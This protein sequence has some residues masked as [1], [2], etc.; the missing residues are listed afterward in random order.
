MYFKKEQKKLIIKIIDNKDIIGILPTGFG[1]TLIYTFASLKKPFLTLVFSPLVALIKDQYNNLPKFIK[2]RT[3]FILN[4]NKKQWDLIFSKIN[5][6]K[7]KILYLSPE[8]LENKYILDKLNSFYISHIVLDEAHTFF[9][10]GQT[11]R[12]SFKK[13]AIFINQKRKKQNFSVSVFTATF[14]KKDIK[15]IKQKLFLKSPYILYKSPIRKNIKQ[16]WFLFFKQYEKF[17]KLTQILDENPNTS[18]IIYCSTIELVENLY[19]TL[20]SKYK[21]VFMFHSKLTDGQ[22]QQNLKIFSKKNIIMVATTAFGMGINKK[23]IRYIIHFTMPSTIEQF[24]QEIGRA[25]RD[26]KTSYSYVFLNPHDLKINMSFIK[27]NKTIFSKL[28][29]LNKFRKLCFLYFRQNKN[30]YIKNYFFK[31]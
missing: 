22:K 10:W 15:N 11:F 1:K 29:A 18:I 9:E 19:T 28:K 6:N 7:I 16:S 27:Q 24:I 20:R 5:K 3:A 30:K 2:Q 23:N 17:K 14:I 31:A 21:N 13:I 25:G 8:R 26:K 4:E 12:P